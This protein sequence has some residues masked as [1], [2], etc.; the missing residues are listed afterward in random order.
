M[1]T[2]RRC[3][4]NWKSET[5]GIWFENTV[6]TKHFPLDPGPASGIRLTMLDDPIGRARKFVKANK[7]TVQHRLNMKM[8]MGDGTVIPTPIPVFCHGNFVDVAFSVDI[9]CINR[10]NG[11][12]AKVQLRIEELVQLCSVRQHGYNV[13]H[14]VACKSNN[15]GAH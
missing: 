7:W 10:K 8:H 9:T 3:T 15:S 11:V 13:G 14:I 5:G 2:M 6:F 1:A 12:H 4:F